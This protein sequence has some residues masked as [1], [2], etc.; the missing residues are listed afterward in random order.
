MKKQTFKSVWDAIED[1]EEE[2]TNMKIRSQLMSTLTEK[3]KL[4]K[5]SQAESAKLLGVTQPRI[6]DLFRG[7]VDLFSIDTLVNMLS[8][9]GF[10]VHFETS[11]DAVAA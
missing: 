1:S 6:S 8:K 10:R 9:L 11:N 7:R 5:L 2:A 3:L 4:R